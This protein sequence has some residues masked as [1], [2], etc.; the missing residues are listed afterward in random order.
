MIDLE[1]DC[2]IDE[3]G[4]IYCWGY[5]EFGRI[6]DGTNENKS[7]PTKVNENSWEKVSSHL[8]HTCGISASDKKLYCWGRNEWGE[9]G[10]GSSGF[11][12][13]YSNGY[14]GECNN[15]SS[16]IKISD[17]EW[18]EIEV[19]NNSS[20]GIKKSDN[21]L[22]CWGNNSF[23]Q[24]GNGFTTVKDIHGQITTSYH[25]S[26]PVKIGE[27]SWIKIIDEY[28]WGGETKCAINT[29]NNLF[30]WGNNREGL[31]G[32]GTAWQTVPTSV[33]LQE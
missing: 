2:F 25:E 4:I 13:P 20:C 5:N 3:T 14:P 9:I 1:A 30:C 18:I 32:D 28:N 12:C 24:L 17:D 11:E 23:G 8:R 10:N 31:L 7:S 16:P 26:L 29:Q 22:Y 27:D 15:I 33:P 19:G 6:G 21:A